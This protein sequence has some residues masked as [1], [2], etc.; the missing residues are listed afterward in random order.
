MFK[1]QEH[2]LKVKPSTDKLISHLNKKGIEVI[3]CNSG[4][5]NI[6]LKSKDKEVSISHHSFYGY[7]RMGAVTK[8]KGEK[9]NEFDFVPVT[10][11]MYINNVLKYII[12]FHLSK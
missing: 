4:L 9:V 5:K 11:E 1:E 2:Q 3:P 6:I 10:D 7:S 8:Q 12:D